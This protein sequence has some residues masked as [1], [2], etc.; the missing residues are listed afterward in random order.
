[1]ALPMVT[2]KNDVYTTAI[3]RAMRVRME[4]AEHKQAVLRLLLTQPL[5][6]EVEKHRRS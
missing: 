2:E 5:V 1:M 4:D 3:A 6:L